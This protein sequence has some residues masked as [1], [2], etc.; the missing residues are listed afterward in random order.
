MGGLLGQTIV[1]GGHVPV[2]NSYWDYQSSGIPLGSGIGS[3]TDTGVTGLTTAAMQGTGAATNMSNLSD[4]TT[5]WQT[6]SNGYPILRNQNRVIQLEGQKIYTITFSETNLV[7]AA[8]LQL[9]S[10]ASYLVPFG[11]AFSTNVGI[12]LSELKNA[13]YWFTAAKTGYQTYYG[14]FVVNDAS[15]TLSFTMSNS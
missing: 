4:F 13:S 3:T 1:E 15:F 8:S 12:A 5:I 7:D 2:A 10:D 14:S 11:S 6:V 9:F